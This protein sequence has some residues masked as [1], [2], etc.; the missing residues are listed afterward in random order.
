MRYHV[1]LSTTALTFSAGSLAF[2]ATLPPDL[3]GLNIAI[4]WNNGANTWNSSSQPSS[5]Y[6]WTYDEQNDEYTVHGG[7]TSSGNWSATWDFVL[8]I[9]PF[10]SS[11]FN[12]NNPNV[13]AQTYS[14][15]VT[16]PTGFFGGPTVMT[17]STS[18]SILDADGVGGAIAE[19]PVG[20]AFY[21]AQIDGA[22]AHVEYPFY[23]AVAAPG[24]GTANLPTINWGPLP[25]PGIAANMGIRNDF[26]LSGK[27]TFQMV[28]TFLVNAIPAPGSIAVIGLA[29]LGVA[30][31]RR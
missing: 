7:W 3:N 18:G 26:T 8:E 10:V 15:V 29:G 13:G 22:D 24:A 5:M 25:G 12:L 9:D 11:S 20:G 1:L 16:L 21:R 4:S 31:R 23:S 2:G 30:R 19:T 14:V 27:D 6:G 28:S 17:G